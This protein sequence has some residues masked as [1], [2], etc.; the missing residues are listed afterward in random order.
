MLTDRVSGFFDV[1]V[2]SRGDA[3]FRSGR[4]HLHEFDSER[5]ITAVVEG[6][7]SYAVSFEFER[8][9]RSWVLYADC[10]CPYMDS[11]GGFCK[12]IWA[13]LLAIEESKQE[14][15]RRLGPIPKTV[16]VEFLDDDNG[17]DDED[18]FDALDDDAEDWGDPDD[19]LG[20]TVNQGILREADRILGA[21]PR[22]LVLHPARA[23]RAGSG[24]PAKKQ[25][26]D[27]TPAWQKLLRK[28]PSNSDTGFASRRVDD[29]PIEP[30][31]VLEVEDSR[32]SN[33]PILSLAQ[34][35][36]TAGGKLGKVKKLSLSP[37]DIARI[38]DESDRRICML[39]LGARETEGPYGYYGRYGYEST[40]GKSK[41]NVPPPLQQE[42]FPLLP[43]SGR[44]LLRG[45]R[46][47]ALT[48]LTWDDGEPWE[49]M[50]SIQQSEGGESYALVGQLRRGD[51]RCALGGVECF[52][53]GSPAL[54]V[55]DGAV[56]RFEAC[57]CFAWLDTLRAEKLSTLTKAELPKLLDELARL[58]T[59][60]PVEWPSDWKVTTVD[61][62]S[63]QPELSLRI[64][65]PVS[66][67]RSYPA[68][69]E[70][71]F[72]YG[73]SAVDA[74]APGRMLVDA[75]GLRL[76][77]RQLE[78][79]RQRLNRL[80]DLGAREERS[81]GGFEVHPR[82]I[83]T[84]VS[85][86]VAEGWTVQGNRKLYRR[87]GDFRINVSSG[88]DWF[89]VDGQVDFDGQVAKLPELLAAL[90]K[91]E[92]FVSLGDGSFGM[93]PEEWLTRHQGWLELGRNGQLLEGRAVRILVRKMQRQQH[94]IIT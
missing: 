18:G 62:L 73:D 39:L 6:S 4:V 69:G 93:L 94:R 41:W 29:S 3:Y 35:R 60:P 47:A 65:N 85:A 34:Q 11:F 40:A 43:E 9:S 20:L 49:L 84:L 88:I 80:L 2:R 5:R 46:D 78:G 16:S 92:R 36:M 67:G 55:R 50:L 38:R 58:G 44:F 26:R 53:K 83:P 52:I 15:L 79:E 90:H 59:F 74:A 76:I 87:P 22:K 64:E 33:G 66:H 51:E 77:R 42:L 12:H 28:I 37:D 24:Q 82:K 63:P 19:E 81:G 27:A 14:D 54:F 7:H 8:R 31:Y 30:I 57:G 56:S 75:S 86:L 10:S 21:G 32:Y 68:H 13:T 61:G 1:R 17:L 45:Q 91:G 23:P 71:K 25:R 48:P 72:R 89:D 70:V